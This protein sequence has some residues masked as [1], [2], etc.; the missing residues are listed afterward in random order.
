MARLERVLA[1][2]DWVGSGTT[3]GGSWARRYVNT[4]E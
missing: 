1:R 3:G 2:V 4:V